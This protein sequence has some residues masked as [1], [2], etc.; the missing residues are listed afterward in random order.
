V[1]GAKSRHLEKLHRLI[2]EET[3]LHS[4]TILAQ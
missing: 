1:F 3:A 4:K 2:R